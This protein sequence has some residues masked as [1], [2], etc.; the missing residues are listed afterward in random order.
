MLKIYHN[1]RCQKSRQT[2]QLIQENGAEHTVVEYLNQRLTADELKS[3]I[4][5]LGIKAEALV[6]KSEQVFKDA[7]K[8]KILTEEEWIEAMVSNPKLIERPIVVKGDQA[9]L[10]RPPGN[11]KALF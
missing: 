1:P 6:R 11:V 7:Y 2:L 4:Q 5:K 10:G 8:G 3:L 9:V